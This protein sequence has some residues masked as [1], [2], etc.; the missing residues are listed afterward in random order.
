MDGAVLASVS[1]LS[2]E[3]VSNARASS[4]E[5]AQSF[6]G[7]GQD[8]DQLGSLSH[9]I[10]RSALGELISGRSICIV[11]SPSPRTGD[12]PRP[13]RDATRDKAFGS[14]PVTLGRCSRTEKSPVAG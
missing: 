5:T 14:L 8:C 1:L 3:S 4:F 6:G 7:S 13:S 2:R 9:E 12:F 11:V 10:L